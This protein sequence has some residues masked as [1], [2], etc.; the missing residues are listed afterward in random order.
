MIGVSVFTTYVPRGLGTGFVEESFYG[1]ACHSGDLHYSSCDIFCT[2]F[3]NFNF[4]IFVFNISRFVGD[5]V[6]MY[7]LQKTR[8]ATILRNKVVSVLE[9]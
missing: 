3:A 1:L 5:V 2:I 6:P 7:A 9:H 4:T 8:C